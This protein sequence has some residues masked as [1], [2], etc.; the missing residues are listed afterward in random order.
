[1][2]LRAMKSA[3]LK[4][5]AISALLV[6]AAGCT[7]TRS[8]SNSGYQPSSG[9]R[10]YGMQQ[11]DPA[12]RYKGELSEFEVIGIQ[13]DQAITDDQI[14]K[15]LDAAKPVRVPKGSSILVIQSGA[16]YPDDTLMQQLNQHYHATPFPGIPEAGGTNSY[17]KNLRY[18]A[19]LG[20]HNAILCY[21]GILETAEMEL[22][23]KRLS[24]VPVVGWH[25]PDEKHHMRIRLKMAV[26][27]V[28][29]GNWT[30]FYPQSF[31]DTA[32]SGALTRKNSDQQQVATLKEKAF[33]AAAN[34][35]ALRYSE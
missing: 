31:D 1:M 15:A 8:I 17:A 14:G 9:Y 3:I 27:D 11:G 2:K 23:T 6:L 13:R 7:T 30:M 32:F 26:I 20:G 4:L 22:A 34:D 35:L 19:A 29:T 28:R 24:W 5:S 16:A 33:L 18:A 21:W 12:F 25:L 10:H